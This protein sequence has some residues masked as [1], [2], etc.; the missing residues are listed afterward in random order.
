MAVLSGGDVVAQELKYHDFC[1]TALYIKDRA[2]I[3]TIEREVYALVFSE[4]FTHILVHRLKRY[5]YLLLS[6]LSFLAWGYCTITYSSDDSWHCSVS[7]FLQCHHLHL[8]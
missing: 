6:S 5:Y 7:M 8:I 3:L 4:L 2:Y 1:L